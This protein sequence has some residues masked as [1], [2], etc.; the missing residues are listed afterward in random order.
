MERFGFHAAETIA[1][2]IQVIKKIRLLVAE[3]L[4][5]SE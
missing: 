2:E 3:L 1:L 4:R 5:I